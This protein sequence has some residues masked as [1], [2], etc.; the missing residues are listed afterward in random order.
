MAVDHGTKRKSAE[1]PS[2]F[3]FVRVCSKAFTEAIVASGLMGGLGNRGVEKPFL[4]LILA[5]TLFIYNFKLNRR[6]A[7]TYIYIFRYMRYKS[8]ECTNLP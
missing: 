4:W 2:R 7:Q 3:R 6:D 8:I 5:S 1:N